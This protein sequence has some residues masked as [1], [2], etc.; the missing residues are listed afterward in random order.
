MSEKIVTFSAA[1][2]KRHPD[3]K[4]D[5]GIH[6]VDLRF[7]Y[8]GEKGA[9]QFVLYTNWHLPRVT[10]E[11][12]KEMGSDNY[13][14]FEPMPA[15][16]GYHSPSPQYEGQTSVEEECPYLDGKPCYYDGSGLQA[17]RVY[18]RLLE[19]GDDGVWAELEE[20]YKRLFEEP[21]EESDE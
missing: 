18:V 2:D 4:K 7:V 14:L 20:Q 5:Y 12:R 16:L 6:G 21:K 11:H 19:E 15:D 1:F 17:H 10:E 8:K 3:P 13:F 9:T